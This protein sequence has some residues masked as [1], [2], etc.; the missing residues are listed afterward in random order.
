[1]ANAFLAKRR[2]VCFRVETR[3]LGNTGIDHEANVGNRNGS[4]GNICRKNDFSLAG[5]FLKD[6][7][8]IGTREGTIEWQHPK[9]GEPLFCGLG[10]LKRFLAAQDRPLSGK[11]TENMS[12]LAALV[13]ASDFLD[14]SFRHGIM[15][16]RVD[17][18]VLNIDGICPRLD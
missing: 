3:D 1:M 11:K 17:V 7:F 10:R 5:G 9:I 8:L 2:Y 14:E 6:L 12:R 4:F 18:A 15:V 13:D 16:A